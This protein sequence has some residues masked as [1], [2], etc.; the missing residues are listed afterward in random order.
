MSKKQSNSIK[1]EGNNQSYYGMGWDVGVLLDAK[2]EYVYE[3]ESDGLAWII[4]I[5]ST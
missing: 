2:C 3:G 4:M 1:T 5:K